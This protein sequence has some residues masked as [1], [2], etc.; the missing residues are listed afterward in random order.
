MFSRR[1]HIVTLFGI[2]LTPVF[3]HINASER[4]TEQYRSYPRPV[5]FV[6]RSAT[7]TRWKVTFARSHSE[8]RYDFE[9]LFQAFQIG[10][11]PTTRFG[12]GDPRI[13]VA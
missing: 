7:T 11:A 9:L 4:R 8:S 13:D 12:H 10:I 5:I 2:I 3:V 1:S 6:S